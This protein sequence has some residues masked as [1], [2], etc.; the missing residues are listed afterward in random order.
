MGEGSS[1]I[2]KSGINGEKNKGKKRKM[3]LSQVQMAEIAMGEASDEGFSENQ[4]MSDSPQKIQKLD[5]MS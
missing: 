2:L 5:E 1:H 3:T 4:S